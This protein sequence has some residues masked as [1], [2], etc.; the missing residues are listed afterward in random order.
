MI[1]KRIYKEEITEAICD[2]CGADCMKELFAPLKS[3]GDRDNHDIKKEFEGM[4]L[5]AEWGYNSEQ[6]G[7]VWEACIC[8]KCVK[9]KLVPLINFVKIPY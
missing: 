4:I 5:K 1:K 8:E 3:D 2:S 9:E 6:D 7:E